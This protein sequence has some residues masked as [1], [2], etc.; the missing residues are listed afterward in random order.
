MLNP[1]V[2]SRAAYELM[3]QQAEETLAKQQRKP[4]SAP[5]DPARGSMEW[6]ALQKNRNQ[7]N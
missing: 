3:R 1:P 5:P 7:S 6:Q 4:Q 2:P